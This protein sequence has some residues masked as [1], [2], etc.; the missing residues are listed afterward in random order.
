MTL[1]KF[2]NLSSVRGSHSVH[3]VL[4]RGQY[5]TTSAID[6]QSL[7]VSEQKDEQ[8]KNI[9][10]QCFQEVDELKTVLM[11]ERSLKAEL[12]EELDV[13]EKRLQQT[14]VEIQALSSLKAGLEGSLQTS[15][16]RANDEKNKYQR[17]MSLRKEE[18]DKMSE[19][20]QRLEKDLESRLQQIQALEQERDHVRDAYEQM[21]AGVKS[22]LG[23][24][25]SEY[26]TNVC[27]VFLYPP[28]ASVSNQIL[29]QNR[30]YENE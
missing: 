7:D 5:I 24:C 18:L 23:K 22:E 3:V 10:E 26:L 28:C 1:F 25:T 21:M 12:A 19:K 14:T 8:L 11:S 6:L 16:A 13:R 30:S 9:Q 2:L 4:T 17:E 29:V 27:C 20:I 15:N